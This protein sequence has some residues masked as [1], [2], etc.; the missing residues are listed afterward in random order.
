MLMSTF[1]FQN[2]QAHIY[3]TWGYMALMASMVGDSVS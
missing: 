3:I 2:M 1:G